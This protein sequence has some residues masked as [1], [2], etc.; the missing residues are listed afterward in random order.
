MSFPTPEHLMLNSA[1]VGTGSETVALGE[2][3]VGFAGV[4]PVSL[5]AGSDGDVAFVGVDGRADVWTV[6]AG[7]VIPVAVRTI[8]DATTTV[9]KLHAI[10]RGPAVA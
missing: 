9:T 7:E 4:Y 2:G 10:Y 6:V 8:T 5:R 3:D 1:G